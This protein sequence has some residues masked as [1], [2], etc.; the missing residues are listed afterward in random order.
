MI[1]Q[2]NFI[3][4]KTVLKKKRVDKKTSGVIEKTQFRQTEELHRKAERAER[5]RDYK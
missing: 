5:R 2:K 4:K 3:E 1:K